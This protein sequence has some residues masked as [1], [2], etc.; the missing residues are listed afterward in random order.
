MNVGGLRVL[1]PAALAAVLGACAIAIPHADAAGRTKLHPPTLLW[2]SYPLVQQARGPAARTTASERREA[3]GPTAA[4][5]RKLDDMLLLTVLLA[6][7][8]A[9]GTVVFMRR[10]AAVRAGGSVRRGAGAGERMRRG[11]ERRPRHRRPEP[12]EASLPPPLPPEL[13]AEDEAMPEAFAGPD[14]AREDEASPVPPPDEL[15]RVLDDLLAALPPGQQPSTEPERIPEVE[16]RELIV[17]KNMAPA[18]ARPRIEREI[19][20][21]LERVESRRAAET[22][23][24]AARRTSLARSE[25]RLWHGV[26]KSRLYAVICGSD[27]AFAVS[28]WFRSRDALAPGLSA[29]HALSSFLAELSRVGWMVVAHGSAWYEHTLE[30]VPADVGG[31]SAVASEGDVLP[32][33]VYKTRN[34]QTEKDRP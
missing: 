1:R 27:D 7:L 24:R 34:D 3:T 31:S 6:T 23:A 8:L 17:R 19:D 11:P 10:P 18:S 32:T 22:R 12:Q 14:A 9:A 33:I 20:A 5:G 30:L 28:Q 25:I 4:Q 13:T 15:Q 16:L 21:A 29:Q 26:I 2:K